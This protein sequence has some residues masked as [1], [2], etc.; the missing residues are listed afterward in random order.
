MRFR[1][2]LLLLL[3]EWLIGS[4]IGGCAAS[5]RPAL[6]CPPSPAQETP[7]SQEQAYAIALAHLQCAYPDMQERPACYQIRR[8]PAGSGPFA[9]GPDDP[10]WNFEL[11]QE[12]RTATCGEGNGQHDS[13]GMFQVNKRGEFEEIPYP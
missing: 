7:R 5:V 10:P 9:P 13:L 4:S 2:M 6:E 8:R 11:L 12:K 3:S 1:A